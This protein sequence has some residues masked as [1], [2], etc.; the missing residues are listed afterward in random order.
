MNA[1]GDQRRAE[2]EGAGVP[3]V[4]V[5]NRQ[6]VTS[7]DL[8]WVSRFAGEAVVRCVR[9]SGDGA[10]ALRGMGEVEVTVVSD[11]RIAQIHRDFMGVPGATDVIT[12]QHGEVIVSVETA[13][14]YAREHGHGLEEEI[15]LY[16]VHGFL[17][18]NGFEDTTPELRSRMFAVQDPIWSECLEALR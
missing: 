4:V 18:L 8:E 1:S 10:Y 11:R 15:G 17:H 16:I 9:H 7:V 13:A 3:E 14:M 5:V 12:F 2:G 6:R